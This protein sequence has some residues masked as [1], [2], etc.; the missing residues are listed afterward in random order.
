MQEAGTSFG[1]RLLSRIWLTENR[2]QSLLCI[3][4][5][6]NGRDRVGDGGDTTEVAVSTVPMAEAPRPPPRELAQPDIG[7]RQP[8]ERVKDVHLS[9]RRQVALDDSARKVA[10]LSPLDVH[11]W[12][13]AA[14]PV[15]VHDRPMP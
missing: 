4:G 8:G 14:A 10:V 12:L 2:R 3:F 15:G 11:R 5:P 9:C 6:N 7:Q 1:P 13:T